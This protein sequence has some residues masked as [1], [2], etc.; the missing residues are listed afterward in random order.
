MCEVIEFQWGKEKPHR[1][2]N[3][4]VGSSVARLRGAADGWED[5]G[6][7]VRRVVDELKIQRV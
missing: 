7:I 4:A 2:G 6:S 1:Q 3:K 5:F